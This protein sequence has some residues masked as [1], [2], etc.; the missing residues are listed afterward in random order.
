IAGPHDE[1]ETKRPS[2]TTPTCDMGRIGTI[3]LIPDK[4]RDEEFVLKVVT[5]VEV[6]V[7]DCLKNPTRPTDVK[8]ERGCTVARRALGFVPHTPLV[9]PILMRRACIGV[10]CGPD[11]TCVEGGICES[12]KIVDPTKCATIAGC[13]DVD[14]G[15]GGTGGSSGCGD[16]KCEASESC[17]TC[18]A[19]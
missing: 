10:V 4:S 13:G 8:G 15:G 3:V 6:T 14:L 9:L 2:A 1:V 16:G 17:K 12:D 11:E 7:D 18:P 5:G 19:D